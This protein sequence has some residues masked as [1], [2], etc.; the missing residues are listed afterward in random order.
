MFQEFEIFDECSVTKLD[1]YFTAEDLFDRAVTIQLRK[2]ENGKPSNKVLPYSVV[3]KTPADM[4]AV[5]TGVKVTFTFDETIR[6][7]RGNYAIGIV[8]P[9]VDYKIQTL[10]VEQQKG[11]KGTGVGN[12]FI[13]SQKI[14][15]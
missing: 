14:T 8:T 12:L 10:K 15:D 13:V 9:S 1:L 5:S 6:L 3:S 7:Q 11:S 2:M 4:A